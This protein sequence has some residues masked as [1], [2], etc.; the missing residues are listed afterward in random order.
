MTETGVRERLRK[1][2]KCGW[3]CDANLPAADPV[4][5]IVSRGCD[6]GLRTFK[7]PANYRAGHKHQRQSTHRLM[8]AWKHR[9]TLRSAPSLDRLRMQL[10]WTGAS[11]TE[12]IRNVVDE[13]TVRHY[14]AC[15]LGPGGTPQAWLMGLGADRGTR[16]A[17]ALC[18]SC[19]PCS[20]QRRAR[21]RGSN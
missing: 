16:V 6:L 7:D 14:K 8:G 4:G 18:A 15:E 19:V 21:L 13:I 11:M 3:S 9:I 20:N 1:A 12:R 2:A 5:V 10:R 17:Q